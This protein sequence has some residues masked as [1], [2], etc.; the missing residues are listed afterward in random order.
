MS[1]GDFLRAH[2]ECGFI[3]ASVAKLPYHTKCNATGHTESIH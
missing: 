1:N 3:W 2:L